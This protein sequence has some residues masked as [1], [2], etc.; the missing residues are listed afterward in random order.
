MRRS[1][2]GVIVG[3]FGACAAMSAHAQDMTFDIEEA[4]SETPAEGGEGGEGEG[5]S[6]SEAEAEGE[7]TAEGGAE[8]GMDLGGDIIGE[9]AGGGDEQQGPRERAPRST[10]TVEEIYAVQQIYALRINRVELSPSFG[11]TVNDQYVSHPSAGVAL[12]YWWTN[13]LAVGLS[14][15]WYEGLENESDL[16]FFVAR[17]TRLAVPITEYQLGAHLNFT[18]VPLYG[19]FSMFNEYIFQWDA[20][21]V[22]GVGVLRTRPKPVIDPTVRQFNFDWRVA[23]NAGIGIRVFITRFL[24]VFGE[25]RDYAYLERLENLDVG[26]GESRNDPGTWLDDSPSLTN[27]VTAHLGFTLFLPFS[28]DYRLPK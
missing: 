9:L 13:V 18:Y 16:N 14:F 27:N 10:E 24:A 7:G 17:S 21:V 8:G 26:L 3:L 5:M 19:K 23:F 6:F 22:G 4:E 11:I 2:I 1:L 15:L 12:N 20:Y 25:L 28:F